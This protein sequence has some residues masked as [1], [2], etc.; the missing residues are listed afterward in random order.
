MQFVWMVAI[1]L[2]VGC[3][4]A[5]RELGLRPGDTVERVGAPAS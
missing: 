2:L 1:G 4:W 5:G 3:A